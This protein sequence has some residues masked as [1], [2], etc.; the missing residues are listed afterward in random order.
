M[1]AVGMPPP[2]G[3]TQIVALAELGRFVKATAPV[4]FRNALVL[5]KGLKRFPVVTVWMLHAPEV[6]TD[7]GDKLQWLLPLK[8]LCEIVLTV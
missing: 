3:A 4:L 5:R 2:G 6:A 7:T 1:T 8:G